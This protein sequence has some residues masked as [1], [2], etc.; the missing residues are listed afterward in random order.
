MMQVRPAAQSSQE[1]SAAPFA[2]RTRAEEAERAQQDTCTGLQEEQRRGSRS[3]AWPWAGDTGRESDPAAGLRERSRV[4]GLASCIAW[5]FPALPVTGFAPSPVN[6][7]D[8]GQEQWP[9]WAMAREP[10]W[11]GLSGG[12]GGALGCTG[13]SP[14]HQHSPEHVRAQ[15][16]QTPLREPRAASTAIKS[17]GSSSPTSWHSGNLPGSRCV[18]VSLAHLCTVEKHCKGSQLIGTAEVEKQ[19]PGNQFLLNWRPVAFTKPGSL[20]SPA[21]LRSP[22]GQGSGTMMPTKAP[23]EELPVLLS[24]GWW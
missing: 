16:L 6:W 1:G 14:Q 18:H 24:V 12:S 21:F 23:P 4:Q 17:R 2:P 19:N 13:E 9:P 11:Q 8:F 3:C 22:S 7:E 15:R 20:C 5:C 10:P